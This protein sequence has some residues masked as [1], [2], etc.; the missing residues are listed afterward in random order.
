M[1]DGTGRVRLTPATL[2]VV[3]R[4][5]FS[6]HVARHFAGGGHSSR[7]VLAVLSPVVVDNVFLVVVDVVNT[8]IISSSGAPAIAAVTVVSSLNAVLIGTL[9]AVALGSTV[10]VAQCLGA[11]QRQQMGKAATATLRIVSLLAIGYAGIGWAFREPL[12]HSLFGRVDTDVMAGAQLFFAG[13]L[14]SLP[15]FGVVIGANGVLRG[16]GHTRATL[17]LSLFTNLLRIG[18]SLVL[19]TYLGMGISGLVIAVLVAEYLGAGAAV[20]L[21]YRHRHAL[22][23]RRVYW[24]RADLASVH[25]VM[26]VGI[27]FAAE[28]LLFNGAKLVIQTFIIGFGT[29]QLAAHAIIAAWLR[30]G[31]LVPRSLSI[32]IVPIAGQSLGRGDIGYARRITTSFVITSIIGCLLINLALIPVFPWA[33]EQIFHAPQASYPW[34]WT[35][36]AMGI[37]L[38]PVL[39]SPSSIIPATLRAAGDGVFTTVVSLASM[40]VY[41]IGAGYLVSVVLGY[42]LVGLWA[43]W[44]TEWGVRA[45]IFWL[46]SRGDRWHAHELV[47]VTP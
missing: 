4:S 18:L 47:G 40:W 5:T 22:A 33:M 6:H 21:I 31:E 3:L 44:M 39:Y 7:Q 41:R 26:L 35:I 11:E 34:L 42:E 37:V 2:R 15:A 9:S 13:L 32:A 14:A 27:P 17:A 28:D 10:L 43:V 16:I 23:I 45:M 46:R 24:T 12:L 38:Y 29:Y 30:I 36:F 19:V 25:R 8:A 1:P 20:G